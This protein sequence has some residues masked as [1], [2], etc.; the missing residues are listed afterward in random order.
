MPGRMRLARELEEAARAALPAEVFDYVAGG[1]GDEQTLRENEEAWR[2]LWLRPRQLLGLAAPST[3]VELLGAPL[4]LP[5]LVAARPGLGT[6]NHT[7]LTLEAA[8]AAGLTVAAVVLTPWSSVPTTVE[9]SNRDT[10]ARLGAVDVAT[11]APAGSGA[12]A[13]LAAAG[14]TLPLDDWL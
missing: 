9:A 12:P 14:A 4:A 8:R 7:L 1:A 6:I 3:A 10:I 2:R 11:L 13:D 5:L